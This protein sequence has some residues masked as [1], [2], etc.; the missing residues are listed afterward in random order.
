MT[1]ELLY[2]VILCLLVEIYYLPVVN[3]CLSYKYTDAKN[4]QK[5]PKEEWKK[6]YL[7]NKYPQKNSLISNHSPFL[8]T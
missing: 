1:F 4:K 2:Q 3:L 6:K 5:T 7:Q 8:L